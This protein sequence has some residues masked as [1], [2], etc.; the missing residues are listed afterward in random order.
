MGKLPKVKQHQKP[1]LI[2]QALSRKQT[3]ADEKNECMLL[4]FKHLDQNQGQNFDEWQINMIL[5]DAMGTLRNYANGTIESQVNDKFKSYYGFPPSDKTEFTH[6]RHVPED[7]IWASMHVTGKQCLIG[8][9][10]RNV[11]YLVFL[12]RDHRFW[13]SEL[14]NT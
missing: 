14:K 12:D 10:V 5:A 1:S 13:I 2:K 11:F 6:P 4:S 3:V 7:A 8:H 9:I